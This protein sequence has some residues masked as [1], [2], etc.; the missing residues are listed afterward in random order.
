MLNVLCLKQQIKY[1]TIGRKQ[2]RRKYV[3][4]T[5]KYLKPKGELMLTPKQAPLATKE[6]KKVHQ[7]DTKVS[8]PKVESMSTPK[9]APPTT[10]ERK[11]VRQDGNPIVLEEV[12]AMTPKLE[13]KEANSKD[14]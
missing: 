10:E 3:K 6:R 1:W 8:K 12:E 2:R 11:N 9:L 5:L 4:M 7:D 14:D 13:V